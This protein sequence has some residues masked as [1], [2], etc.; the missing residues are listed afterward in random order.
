MPHISL[1]DHTPINVLWGLTFKNRHLYKLLVF[2][3]CSAA[4]CARRCL[5]VVCTKLVSG[6]SNDAGLAT[7]N[8]PER[9][10]SLPDG[11]AFNEGRLLDLAND[12]RMDDMSFVTAQDAA[13][14]ETTAMFHDSEGSAFDEEFP[15][16]LAAYGLVDELNSGPF[17]R[18][19]TRYVADDGMTSVLQ[20]DSFDAAAS[21]G[22]PKAVTIENRVDGMV[23]S[24]IEDALTGG[25]GASEDLMLD[26]DAMD[27]IILSMAHDAISGRADSEPVNLYVPLDEMISSMLELVFFGPAASKGRY[28]PREETQV[29]SNTERSQDAPMCTPETVSGFDGNESMREM[30]DHEPSSSAEDDN[31]PGDRSTDGEALVVRKA[32]K[33]R[34]KWPW[35][36]WGRVR[37]KRQ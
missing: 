30:H 27:D 20:G 13:H 36:I 22:T 32:R 3:V 16:D 15:F 1:C 14:D 19:M 8:N 6:V 4:S 31:Q 35:E 12:G 7:Y 11:T 37:R 34:W 17:D 25:K 24:V 29:G 28:S 23:W 5:R 33:G 18:V 2:N 10:D 9:R 26:D 21:R